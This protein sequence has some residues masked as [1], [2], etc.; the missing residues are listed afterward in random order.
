[1]HH[2]SMFTATTSASYKL[3]YLQLYCYLLTHKAFKWN[4]TIQSRIKCC[5]NHFFYQYIN[6]MRSLDAMDQHLRVKWTKFRFLKSYFFRKYHIHTH[7]NISI[8]AKYISGK[9]I[10]MFTQTV[11]LWT[12]MYS[13]DLIK[14]KPLQQMIILLSAQGKQLKPKQLVSNLQAV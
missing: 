10:L 11:Y 7:K 12:N 1:M 5:I 13:I 6:I 14:S 8:I 4:R 2:I 3:R 9:H